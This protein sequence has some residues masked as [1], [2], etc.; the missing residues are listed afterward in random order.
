MLIFF[1]LTH[2]S[3]A[4][5]K[6]EKHIRSIAMW[7]LTQHVQQFGGVTWPFGIH[8]FHGAEEQFELF[9]CDAVAGQHAQHFDEQ[10][11]K[12]KKLRTNYKNLAKY[13]NNG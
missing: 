3:F 11:C 8:R 10:I 4:T 6:T 12:D 13:N 9:H 7:H 1:G 5:W 2:R